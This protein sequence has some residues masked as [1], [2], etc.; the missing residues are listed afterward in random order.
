MMKCCES[1]VK[2]R[3]SDWEVGDCLHLALRQ[4]ET[5]AS[6]RL[7]WSYLADRTIIYKYKFIIWSSE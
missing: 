5:D 1:I 7:G 3:S 4:T 6:A 2:W